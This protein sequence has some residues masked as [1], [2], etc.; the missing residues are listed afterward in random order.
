[1]LALILQL[2]ALVIAVGADGVFEKIGAATISMLMFGM[3]IE[4][5]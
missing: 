1:M 5:V 4:R 3:E 2:L